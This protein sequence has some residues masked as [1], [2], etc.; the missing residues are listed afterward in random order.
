MACAKAGK[1]T[2]THTQTVAVAITNAIRNIASYIQQ[3]RTLYSLRTG[4]SEMYILVDGGGGGGG[5]GVLSVIWPTLCNPDS[6]SVSQPVRLLSSHPSTAHQPASQP[7]TILSSLS[8][9]FKS[10]QIEN[11]IYIWEACLCIC[12]HDLYVHTAMEIRKTEKTAIPIAMCERESVR[13]SQFFAIQMENQQRVHRC[14]CC[15]ALAIFM[16]VFCV[17][18]TKRK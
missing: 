10:V 12:I 15:C 7:A 17:Y 3:E 13:T 16:P 14:S 8:S 5:G 2:S 11:I 1:S 9:H 4:T 6:Q 18:V